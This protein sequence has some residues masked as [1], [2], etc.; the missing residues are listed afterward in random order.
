MAFTNLKGNRR[1]APTSLK[2]DSNVKATILNGNRINHTRGNS[3]ITNKA[4]GQQHMNRKHQ[5]MSAMRVR[6]AKFIFVFVCTQKDS[7]FG[8]R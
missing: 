1:M 5:R 3:T 4:M 2:T 8:R 6:I 7:H